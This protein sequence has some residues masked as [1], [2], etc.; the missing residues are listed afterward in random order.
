MRRQRA[1]MSSSELRASFKRNFN[2]DR[3]DVDVDK[4]KK[5]PTIN[6]GNSITGKNEIIDPDDFRYIE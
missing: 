2:A 3:A 1:L 4:L 5:R 6:S